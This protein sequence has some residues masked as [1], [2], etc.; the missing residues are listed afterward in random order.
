MTEPTMT[1]PLHTT[2]FPSETGE[3]RRARDELLRAEIELRR[4]SEAVNAQRRELPLGG[5]VPTD[6]VFEG[7]RRER[8]R[9]IG[10]A[11]PPVLGKVVVQ[12]ALEAIEARAPGSLRAAA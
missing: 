9:Q 8:V 2:R 6:Y 3:Y 1:E 10:N 11:V 5:E 7:S 4:N 12:A